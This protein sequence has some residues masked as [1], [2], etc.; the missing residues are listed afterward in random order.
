MTAAVV[1]VCAERQPGATLAQERAIDEAHDFADR[2][3]LKVIDTITDPYGNPDPQARVGW[4]SVRSLAAGGEVTTVIVRW[5]NA[6]S[7]N[8]EARY[9]EIAHL[10]ERGVRVLFSWAPLA[11]MT[12]AEAS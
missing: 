12:S 6:I 3:G 7:A 9:G 4:Q 10:Q 2:H 1:Y 8:H 11:T 5:P